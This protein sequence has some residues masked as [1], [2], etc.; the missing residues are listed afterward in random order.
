MKC[1]N[2]SEERE[3]R[4]KKRK[5]EKHFASNNFLFFP[6]RNWL[7]VPRPSWDYKGLTS[8][9]ITLTSLNLTFAFLMNNSASFILCAFLYFNPE[10]LHVFYGCFGT[11]IDIVLISLINLLNCSKDTFIYH[12]L[13]S[14]GSSRNGLLLYYSSCLIGDQEQAKRSLISKL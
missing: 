4:G 2:K 1:E 5:R 7:A 12:V 14:A 10:L 8:G 13:I 3:G 11:L 6:R 9:K